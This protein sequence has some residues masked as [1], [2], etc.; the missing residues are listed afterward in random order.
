MVSRNSIMK[1]KKLHITYGKTVKN[2]QSYICISKFVVRI[3]VSV[4]EYILIS[5]ALNFFMSQFLVLLMD[6]L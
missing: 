6:V 1:Y 5:L 2:K 4:F 3:V